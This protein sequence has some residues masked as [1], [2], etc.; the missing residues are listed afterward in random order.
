[1]RWTSNKPMTRANRDKAFE[2]IES[3]LLALI[4]KFPSM[5][6]Q[7]RP[8]TTKRLDDMVALEIKLRWTH[9][10]SVLETLWPK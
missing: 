4:D 2:R 9:L 3:E 8:S 5:K 6:N 7:E 10:R 1:M